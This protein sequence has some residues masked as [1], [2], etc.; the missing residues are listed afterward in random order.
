MYAVEIK[1]TQFSSSDVVVG[2]KAQNPEKAHTLEPSYVL[3][4]KAGMK[5][6]ISS[7]VYL[8]GREC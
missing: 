2:F 1:E 6:K 4:P 7:Q 8:S 3:S 5:M